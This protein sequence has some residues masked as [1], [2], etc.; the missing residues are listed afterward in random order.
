M[1]WKLTHLL[2]SIYASLNG[3]VLTQARSGSHPILITL[4]S[5]FPTSLH[6]CNFFLLFLLTPCTSLCLDLYVDS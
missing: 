5:A 1:Q 2:H 3:N 6:P 4:S